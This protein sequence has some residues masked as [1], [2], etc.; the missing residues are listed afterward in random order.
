M[1]GESSA[2]AY[3]LPD[4]NRSPTGSRHVT[5]GTQTGALQRRCTSLAAL[6]QVGSSWDQYGDQTCVPCISS[7]IPN[8]WTTKEVLWLIIYL[9]IFN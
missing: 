1:N 3:T 2:E 4:Y 5:Q 8:P 9:F 6:S 7:Q